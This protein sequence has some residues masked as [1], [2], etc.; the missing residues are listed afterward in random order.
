MLGRFKSFAALGF[1]FTISATEAATL[2]GNE[3]CWA[4]NSRQDISC[5]ALTERFLLS[6]EGATEDEVVQAMGVRGRLTADGFLHFT[7]NYA[8]GERGA[9]GDVNFTFKSGRAAIIS[10]FV[11]TS[12]EPREFLWNADLL[13]AACFDGS[14]TLKPCNNN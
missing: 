13:P 10:A 14:A 7:S 12:G 8:Q 1:I 3:A 9:T 11:D 6:I 5:Q 4:D 2:K